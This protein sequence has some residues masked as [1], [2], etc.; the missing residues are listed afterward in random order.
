VGAGLFNSSVGG[1]YVGEPAP[2]RLIRMVSFLPI[3]WGQLRR[4]CPYESGNKLEVVR[5]IFGILFHIING[6][7]L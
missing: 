5:D 3:S 1:K 2:T 7:S 4:D 6:V